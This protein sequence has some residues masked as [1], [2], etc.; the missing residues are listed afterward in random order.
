ML[1]TL[2]YGLYFLHISILVKITVI[3]SIFVKIVDF[4][5]NLK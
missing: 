2:N 1:K 5:N 3:I 4:V